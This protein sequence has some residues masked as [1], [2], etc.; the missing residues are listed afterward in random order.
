MSDVF[1]EREEKIAALKHD[2]YQA[3]GAEY[4]GDISKIELSRRLEKAVD[5]LVS[6]GR[7][8]VLQDF[9]M[10]MMADAFLGFSDTEWQAIRRF[11]EVNKQISKWD[12]DE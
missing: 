8:S 10:T 12:K 6:L 3:F 7:I 9:D 11:F 4:C 5:G 2:I 1:K